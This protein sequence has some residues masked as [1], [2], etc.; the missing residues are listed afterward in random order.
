[1]RLQVSEAI[2]G[3]GSAVASAPEKKSQC[4]SSGLERLCLISP[5]KAI[6]HGAVEVVDEGV[7]LGYPVVNRNEVSASD[8]LAGED[9]EPDFDLV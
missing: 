9:R 5:A 8:H 7:E 3:A 6:C 1:M 4:Q 2:V